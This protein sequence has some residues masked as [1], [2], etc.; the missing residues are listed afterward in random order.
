ML[1]LAV[2][3]GLFLGTALGWL[4]ALFLVGINAV[5]IAYVVQR[6]SRV[7]RTKSARDAVANQEHVKMVRRGAEAVETWRKE[8]PGGRLELRGASLHDLDLRRADLRGADLRGAN[9]EWTRLEEANLSKANLEKARLKQADVNKA[10]LR[11]A[12]LERAELEKANL[13]EANLHKANLEGALK[14]GGPTIW[15]SASGHLP[16]TP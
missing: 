14:H 5:V 8:N 15:P 16:R 9:L 6:R 10:N 2:K 13:G 4:V 12:N 7:P 11:K 1:A 3:W